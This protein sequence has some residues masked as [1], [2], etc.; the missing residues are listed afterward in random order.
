MTSWSDCSFSAFI[1]EVDTKHIFRVLS[2][3]SGPFQE[4]NMINENNTESGQKTFTFTIRVKA[5]GKISS[6]KGVASLQWPSLSLAPVSDPTDGHQSLHLGPPQYSGFFFD[7]F[8]LR[9]AA[10]MI[11]QQPVDKD[12]IDDET[13]P[14]ELFE[15]GVADPAQRLPAEAVL[16]AAHFSA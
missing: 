15:D 14:K 1:S 7:K 5:W 11:V 3:Q 13:P 12:C 9:P 16:A 2:T 4:L 6:K 8:G 10:A